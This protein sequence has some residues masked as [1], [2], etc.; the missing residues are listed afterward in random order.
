MQYTALYVGQ[1]VL[2]DVSQYEVWNL[3]LCYSVY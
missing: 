2:Y 1:H 3:K